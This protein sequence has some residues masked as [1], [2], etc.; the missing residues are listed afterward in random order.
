[1]KK[2]S[3]KLTEDKLRNMIKEAT[4]QI[5]KEEFGNDEFENAYQDVWDSVDA[6]TG[7]VSGFYE[8]YGRDVEDEV[9]SK[10][11]EELYNKSC[12]LRQ[13]AIVVGQKLNILG[14]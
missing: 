6:A 2:N 1:M 4:R 10:M 13:A 5:L 8:M 7:Q 11:V 12:Q 14:Y 3:I 9:I